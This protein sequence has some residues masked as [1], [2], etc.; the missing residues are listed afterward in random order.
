MLAG[1][2]AAHPSLREVTLTLAARAI[3][4]R[5]PEL[6]VDAVLAL[7][8]EPLRCATVRSVIGR[9]LADFGGEITDE[10]GPTVDALLADQSLAAGAAALGIISWAGPRTGWTPLWQ[11]RIR[12]LRRHPSPTIASWAGDVVT[13]RLP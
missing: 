3:D 6:D 13:V 5:D 2:L 4:W 10:L 11:R 7:V 1:T 8:D 12:M 9:C